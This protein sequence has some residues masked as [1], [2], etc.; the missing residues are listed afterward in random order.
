MYSD[1]WGRGSK[2]DKMLLLWLLKIEAI[3]GAAKCNYFLR[4]TETNSHHFY[5]VVQF[6]GENW[7]RTKNENIFGG[8]KHNAVIFWGL[9]FQVSHFGG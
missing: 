2:F 7:R 1:L 4:V 6:G 8:S 3:S 5:G 9:K